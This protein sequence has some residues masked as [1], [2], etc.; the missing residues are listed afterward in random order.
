[1]NKI[2]YLLAVGLI[3]AASCKNKSSDKVNSTETASIEHSDK[4]ATSQNSLDWVGV[5]EGTYNCEGCDNLKA[6]ITLR[7]NNTYLFKNENIEE[8]AYILWSK[9]GSIITLSSNGKKFKVAENKLIA[10]N[11]E[12]QP[13]KGK[14]SNE[15]SFEKKET[16]ETF[17][18]DEETT[19]EEVANKIKEFLRGKFKDE[20]SKNVLKEN[21][22]QFSFYELDLNSDG[23]NEYMVSLS[24]TY[25]CGV[26]G[27]NHYLLNN[28]FTVNTYF[29]VMISP[30]F[31]SSAKTNGWNDLIMIGEKDAN[32]NSL[33][34]IHLK[35]NA[36]T[37]SYPSN[38][39]LVKQTEIAPNGHD[40]TMWYDGYGFAK[41][42]TF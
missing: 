7:P 11:N 24:G 18:F 42:F 22:R 31:R 9:D 30:I 5:Y 6:T 13:L 21:D 41:P 19:N 39:T 2:N 38:P 28:D 26:G 8:K 12:E 29:T 20:L 1:M 25:N 14:G 37:K 36:K 27:C 3:F 4:A 17:D 33:K 23:K 32:G 10:L 34:F 15:I 40:M 16:A 35:Y